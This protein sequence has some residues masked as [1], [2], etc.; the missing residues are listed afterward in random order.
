MRMRKK[1]WAEPELAVCPFFVGEAVGKKGSWAEAYP[2]KQPIWLE[3]GCGKGG[4]LAQYALMR[5]DINFL[6][7]DMISDMLGVARRTIQ[8]AF[9]RENRPVDN[10]LLTV[11]DITRMELFMGE[12]DRVERIFINFCNPW[13]R[14]KQYK[15]RL[16]H[17]RQLVKYRRL[18]PDGGEI[19]F[20]TDSDMLFEHSLCYFAQAGFAIRYETRDLHAS[21]FAPNPLTEHENMYTA[22]GIKIKFLIAEK[23]PEPPEGL[24]GASKREEEMLWLSSTKPAAEAPVE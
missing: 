12:T 21:G 10:L 18:L 14:P 19:W 23:L 3:L 22:E 13:F 17:F 9:D 4:F 16:T 11:F 2:K 24:P 5:P 1:K 20:K 8:S 7:V 6:G 15:K